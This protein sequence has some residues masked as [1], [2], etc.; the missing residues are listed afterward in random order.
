MQQSVYRKLAAQAQQ[1]ETQEE[2]VRYLQEHLSR[3]LRKKER[4]L[5]LFPEKE[6]MSGQILEKALLRCEC[7]PIWMGGDRRWIQILK[8][9]FTT[10]CSCIIGQPLM[11]LGLSKLAKYMG[12]P[13]Y[14]KNVLMCGYPTTGWLV[15]G[16]RQGLD[17]MVWGCFDLGPAGIIIGFTC[18]QLDG[19]HIREDVY[20]VEVVDEQGR[21]VPDGEAGRLAFYPREAPELRFSVAEKGRLIRDACSCGC[22]EAKLVDVYSDREEIWDL[23]EL[24]ARLHHWTSILDCRME[25]TEY[26]LELELVVFPGEKLPKLP[27][28]AKLVVRAFNPEQDEPFHHDE[29]LKNRYLSAKTH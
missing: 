5:I 16:V 4:V 2:T 9:A 7:V 3:F 23:S 21:P 13:L 20:T 27:S 28:T 15:E 26:G 14:V 17:C 1:P 10:R 11:L 12:T 24:S 19:V 22:K 29:A 8:T 6:N 18:Q 25:K